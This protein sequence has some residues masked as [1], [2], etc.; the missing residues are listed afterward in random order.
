MTGDAGGDFPRAVAVIGLGLIGGSLGLDLCA[1]GRSAVWGWDARPGV[2]AAAL[3][4]GAITATAALPAVVAA[5]DVVIIAVP[6]GAIAA[7]MAEISPHLQHGTIVSDVG[8]TKQVVCGWAA[9]RLPAHSHFI[10]GHPMAGGEQHGIAHARAGLFRG[11]RYC[12]TPGAATPAPAL[13]RLAAL[14][15]ALGAT[16]F[17]CTPAEHDRY[18]AAISH[19]PFVLATA[20]VD[21][22]RAQP[23]WDTS[24]QLAASGFRDMSRLAA[25]DVRMHRDIC[26][27]NAEALGPLLRA[28]AARLLEISEQLGDAEALEQLFA[29]VQ[30]VRSAWLL[31]RE[32]Q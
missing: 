19:L 20:L 12:L 7:V 6:V 10:G 32:P 22:V 15:A 5:A 9:E 13:A 11:A 16:P 31:Q 8:S 3:A 2:A 4:R 21:V 23:D 29:E 18:V 26:L 17:I 14:V 24:Q 25:G 30:A 27:T 1:L 28:A